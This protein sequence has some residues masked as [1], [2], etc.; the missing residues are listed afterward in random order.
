MFAFIK[1][2]LTNDERMSY[3][4]L[5]GEPYS[6][7]SDF[8]KKAKIYVMNRKVFTEDFTIDLRGKDHVRIES[9]LQLRLEKEDQIV[10]KMA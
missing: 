4:F 6:G 7:K 8:M 5:K 9:M 3:F 10:K 1:Q 2:Y